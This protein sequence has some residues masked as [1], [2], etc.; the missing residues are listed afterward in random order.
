MNNNTSTAS[1][2]GTASTEVT[3]IGRRELSTGKLGYAYI[4]KDRSPRYYKT[5][6]V[7]GAQIGQRITIEGPAE[8]RNVYYSKG[9]RAPRI[10]GFDESI[11]PGTLTLWQVTDRA[12]YQAKADLD[13]SNRA[14]KQAAYMEQHIAA[15]T[16]AARNLTGPQRAAFARYVEDRIRGW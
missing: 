15:L 16:A 8:D 1:D 14:A 2:P 7:T 13:A 12:A 9:P 5:A 4:D 3:Y 6:L 10:I 11:D